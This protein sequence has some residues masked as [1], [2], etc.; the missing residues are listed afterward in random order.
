MKKIKLAVILIGSIITLTGCIAYTPPS[1]AIVPPEPVVVVA[2]HM[3]AVAP[4]VAIVAPPAVVVAP[5]VVAITPQVEVVAPMVNVELVPESYTWDGF[6]YVGIV[7]GG[8]VYLGSGG[9]WYHCESWRLNRFHGWERNGH[10]DW[11]THAIRNNNY[12]GRG[13]RGNDRR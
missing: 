5:P 6:E 2:P 12:R 11:R 3:V 1:F 10:A 7:G 13:V 9:V 4:P 8:Y